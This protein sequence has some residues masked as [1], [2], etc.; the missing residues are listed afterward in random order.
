MFEL[1]AE[2][3]E[4]RD[5]TTLA[6]GPGGGRLTLV[7]TFAEKELA[8][9][10][11]R[12]I[13]PAWSP[14]ATDLVGDAWR[15]EWKK[16]FAPFR[17]TPRITVRPPW[18]AYQPRDASEIVLDLEPGRAFG[19]GLHATTSLVARAS[20]PAPLS[21]PASNSWTWGQG[22]A[23]SRSSR[24]PWGRLACARSTSIPT[25]PRSR[26]KMPSAMGCASGSR[27]IPRHSMPSR[28]PTPW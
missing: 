22:A 14:R 23:F 10:A 6:S 13:D 21:S 24:S 19:T 2:G 26:S 11:V 28:D 12:E 17:L 3:I 18:E 8:A 1:G 5:E 20:K 4:E 15:D 9:A 7:A 27:P 16:H 25:P